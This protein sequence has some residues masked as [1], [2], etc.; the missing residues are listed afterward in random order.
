MRVVIFVHLNA[1]MEEKKRVLVFASERLTVCAFNRVCVPARMCLKT[2]VR[3]R[4]QY[5]VL[6]VVFSRA[7][8]I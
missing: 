8:N 6:T 5:L 2:R 3:R 7:G 4:E 1:H